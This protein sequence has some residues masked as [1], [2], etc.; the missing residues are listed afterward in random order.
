MTASRGHE[1]LQRMNLLMS[2]Q[3]NEMW[4]VKPAGRRWVSGGVAWKAP[5]PSSLALLCFLSALSSAVLLCQAP[6]LGT[7]LQWLG[8]SKTVN[9]INLSSFRLWVQVWYLGDKKIIKIDS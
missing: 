5:P 9:Q 6:C 7:S 4:E 2:A 3:L 8:T 1:S